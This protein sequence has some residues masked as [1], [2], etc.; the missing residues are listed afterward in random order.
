MQREQP[1]GPSLRETLSYLPVELRFGTSGLRG[2]VADITQLEAYL[3]TRGFL[4]WL[5]RRRRIRPG[6]PL[7]CAGDLRPS[8][9][10][11]VAEQAGRGEILQAVLRAA[12]DSGLRP[13]YLGKI[14]TPAL[15]HFAARRRAASV[16]VTGSHI[17]FERNGIKYNTP[18]GEVLKDEEAPILAAVAEARRA[19]YARPAQS[20]LFDAR[21]MLKPEHRRALPPEE[22]QGAE[23]YRQRYLEAFPAGA[24]AGARILVWQH[25]AVGRDL[26]VEVLRALGAQAVPAGRT[27]TFLAIDTEAVDSGLLADAQALL[28]AALAEGTPAGQAS[29]ERGFDAVV[30]T[31]GDGDRPLLLA[32]EGDRLRFVPGDLLGLLAAEFLGAG[33]VTVPVN[34]SD[35][36]ELHLRPRGVRL[37]RTRIGSPY[38]IA[39][40]RQVGW[41][42]NGGFL[43]AETLRVPAGGQLEPLPTRDSLLPILCALA[44]ARRQGLGLG[45]L[46]DRLPRRFGCS[47]LVRPYPAGRFAGIAAAFA[48]PTGILEARFPRRGVGGGAVPAKRGEPSQSAVLVL[49]EGASAPQPVRG[50]AAAQALRD[51]CRRLEEAFGAQAGPSPIA[52]V[53]W[54][55]GLRVGFE[56]G[57]IAHLRASG[58]APE[59]RLYA[60]AGSQEE[61]ELIAQGVLRGGALARLEGLAEERQAA[62]GLAS[63]P[64]PLLLR[65]AVRHYAWGGTRFIP[66]LL[67][68][69]N[70]ENEPWAELW[71]GAHP[72]APAAAQLEHVPGGWLA[73]DRL[74]QAAPGALLGAQAMRRFGS[75]LPFLLKVL[76]ARESLSIQVHPARSQAREGFARENAEGLPRD[77]PQRSYP[78]PCAKLEVQAAL[79]RLWMLHG[80]RPA[81]EI[82]ALPALVPE[83]AGLFAELPDPGN[84]PK[85]YTHLMSLPQER[86]D[87]VLKPLLARLERQEPGDKDSPDFWAL[88]T[89]RQHP[90]PDGRADRGLFSI[91]LLNLVRLEPGQGTF[92]PPGLLHAYLEG[93]NVELMSSSDNVLRAGLTAKK[94]DVPELLRAVDF[95][96]GR[97]RILRARAVSAVEWAYAAP[98]RAF[99]LS[100]IEL[101]AAGACRLASRGPQC[102]LLTQG[103]ATLEDGEHRL[104]LPR[105][106]AALVPAGLP[107]LACAGAATAVLYRASLP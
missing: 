58:N 68:L 4:A 95:R 93:T 91:Y 63:S 89:A 65:G 37:R 19:E 7:Y 73:L 51:T 39:A 84:L 79:S 92:Q 52:W 10:R 14:P 76:D 26:L 57:H 30:S 81:G 29:G 64:R 17:P 15:L 47:T 80:F 106:A 67:G 104:E 34:A 45:A 42:A 9:D 18:A 71:L 21:G 102:L 38:V 28:D 105:G 72:R 33:D 82:A 103:A 88:R 99:R 101:P 100:R 50:R 46:L 74:I 86:V 6:D 13:E 24:L 44:S 83:L 85:L 32:V 77:S 49:R 62:A 53:N 107:C 61:A 59:L 56:D 40:M 3:N 8:T 87:A 5:R 66:Q 60:V 23:E 54:L 96:G 22:A 2:L 43:T 94:V 75:E 11:L 31:D 35:A 25:S 20:S 1:A 78:D 27:E 70:L 55:D 48:P 36:V 12:Q 98:T 69:A 90:L 16:M 41:E 97:P